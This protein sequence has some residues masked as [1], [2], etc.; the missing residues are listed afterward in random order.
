MKLDLPDRQRWLVIA[1]ATMVALFILDRAVIGPLTATWQAHSAEIGR[2]QK[3]VAAGK[4]TIARET[5]LNRVWSEMESSAM[6]KEPAQAEYAVYT[7]LDQWQRAANI[8]V[9]SVRTQWKRGTTDRFSLCEFRVDAIGSMT[10]LSRFIYD[11]ER[12]AL[13]LRVDSLELTA[14]DE[15]GQRLSLGLIIT[16]L[17]LSPLERNQK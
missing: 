12:S 17:R 7:A 11:L 14:R 3:A 9:T 10:N 4:G 2:L 1:T 6:P 13:P 5:Q 8:E 16:A 15:N